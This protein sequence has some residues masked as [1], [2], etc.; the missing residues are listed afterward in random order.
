[1][2]THNEEFNKLHFQSQQKDAENDKKLQEM[3]LQLNR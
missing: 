2:K 1:M 3:Q